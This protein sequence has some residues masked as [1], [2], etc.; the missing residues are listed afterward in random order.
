MTKKEKVL[1]DLQPDPFVARANEYAGVVE[2]NIR[3]V[4]G[5]IAAALL[6]GVGLTVVGHQKES[7]ASKS[8]AVL[9]KAV[10]AYSEAIDPAKTVTSTTP[11]L[12]ETKAKETL[13]KFDELVKQD[14]GAGALSRLYVADLARRTGDH[15]KAAELYDAYLKRMPSDDTLRFVALEGLGYALEEQGKLDES[16]DAFVKL[17]EVMDKGFQD[18]ALKHQ[19][20]IKEAKGDRE[21]AAKALRELI[22]KHPESKL[23]DFAEQHLATLE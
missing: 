10:E 17:G 22:E 15:A 23:K 18:L 9:T 19:S 2:K 3:V 16:L 14:T 7:S 21:G 11:G 5:V 20:R 8:T 1:E 6:I 12:A 4:V 13:P